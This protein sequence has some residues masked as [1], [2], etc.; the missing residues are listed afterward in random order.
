[1]ARNKTSL[2][3]E[4]PEHFAI[5]VKAEY[6]DTI[7]N[8]LLTAL[9][10]SP[11]VSVRLNQ[12]KRIDTFDSNEAIDWCDNG[13][14]LI[15]RP[16]FAAD[17]FYH[18][19]AYYPQE[20]SSMI[21]DWVLK[22]LQF[23]TNSIE[24]LDVAAAP[25]GKTLILADFL[26]GKGRVIANEID[27]ARCSILEENISRWGCDNVV[28]THG[29]S[30][31]LKNLGQQFQIVLLDAPCS[32]EGMFR[33]DYQARAQWSKDLVASCAKVQ[34]NILNDLTHLVATGG[35]LIY[36]T[37]TFSSQEN[38]DQLDHLCASG[39]FEN[40][41]LQPLDRWGIKLQTGKCASAMQFIP[42]M[43]R[44]EGLT[45]GVLKKVGLSSNRKYKYQGQFR[46]LENRER[47]LI[48]IDSIKMF[49]DS[50]RK[51]YSSSSF[52]ADE[53]NNI[54]HFLPIRKSGITIGQL[55]GDTFIP[56]HELAMASHIHASF[57]SID[58]DEQLARRFLS[59]ETWP[60][61][62]TPGWYRV[63]YKNISLGWIKSLGNRINNYLPKSLRLRSRE[64]RDM[65]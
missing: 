63:E 53:L 9:N 60:L 39:E 11:V 40:I 64:L 61:E 57:P 43:V 58:L 35:F 10:E 41:S 7:A 54:S 23:E 42:G 30:G 14:Y 62:V 4:I 52:G 44:G 50:K 49:Y 65:I 29:S 22:Q 33:K 17:P 13:R 59:G 32:G 31:Q 3:S 55:A 45:M 18:G 16:L 56:N 1:M 12:L 6:S 2:S 25:G 48:P 26:R 8:R 37:C 28:V 27:A 36:S 24:A 5:R 34:K 38:M 46:E 51:H 21:L 47:Q 19:G 15:D 20:S